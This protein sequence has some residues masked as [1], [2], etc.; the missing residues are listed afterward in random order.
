M[1]EFV[2]NDACLGGAISLQ[3]VAELTIGVEKGA[4]ALIAAGKGE[5]SM[6]LSASRGEVEVA[7]GITLADVLTHLLATTQ[8]S[9]RLLSRMATKYPVEDDVDDGEFAAM[10]DWT[11]PAHP[12]SLCLVL[13][14]HS[15]RIAATISDD[16]AWTVDPLPLQV[17]KDPAQ[18][19]DVVAITIDNVYSEDNASKLSQRLD[20]LFKTAASPGEIW[21]QRGRLYPH[22]DFA[23]RVERDLANLGPRPYTAA[24][25]RLD[26]LESASGSWSAPTPRP[27]YLSKVTGESNSTMAKYGAERVFRSSYGSN[28]TF[29]LHARLADGF[30]LHLRE[31]L[32][33][34]RLEIGYVGPHLSIVSEN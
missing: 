21:N 16:P 14:A 27:S 33:A 25:A 10:V 18:P 1:R 22:L 24:L 17:A 6:R 29:E 8:E 12:G 15:Q 5:Q 2:L 31:I 19:A 34:R 9:G 7:A 20:D 11:L 23:P 28:E 13:C 3:R 32:P 26:E 30:R 4:I